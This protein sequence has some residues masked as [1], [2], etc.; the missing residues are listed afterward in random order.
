MVPVAMGQCVCGNA[1]ESEGALCARCLALQ[2]LG[3]TADADLSDIE[4]SYRMLVKVWHPDRFQSDEKLR[5]TAEEKLKAINAAHA[6]LCSG[7]HAQRPGRSS[8]AGQS[9]ARKNPSS[10]A[11]KK[12]AAAV[13]LHTT[14]RFG[15]KSVFLYGLV[16]RC[17][18]LLCACG[19]LALGVVVADT[20][21]SSNPATAHFY[22]AYKA[23][24][25]R[26]VNMQFGS[27]R[28]ALAG[29][30]HLSGNGAA[31]ASEVPANNPPPEAAR[32]EQAHRLSKVPHAHGVQPYVTLG[33]T[34]AEVA[35]VLGAPTAASS[36]AL[37]Y[38]NSLLYM[39]NGRVAGWRIDPASPLRVKLWP[40]RPPDPSVTF[41]TTGSSRSEVIALQGTPTLLRDNTFGYGGSEVF[42]DGDTVVG[43]RND[44]ATVP[45]RV[46]HK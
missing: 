39:R 5:R 15:W 26:S 24:V 23:S 4:S 6:W 27:T 19:V 43:W 14:M 40:S 25:L 44:P 13:E 36:Q 33:L 10:D 8:A 18:L 9:A 7:N 42:F 41:F 34:R 22:A 11:A 46:P 29:V 32:P 12:S 1:V 30:F 21:L 37:L 31:N 17:L 16:L 35:A 20:F 3:L 45:L 2:V 28:R 38:G